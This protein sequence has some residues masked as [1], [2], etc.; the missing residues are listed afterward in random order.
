MEVPTASANISALV[1]SSGP[2]SFIQYAAADDVSVVAYNL[3][4]PPEDGEPIAEG[5]VTDG[6]FT[7]E[8]DPDEVEEG[9]QLLVV[10]DTAGTDI[11]LFVE[12][13]AEGEAVD[14]GDANLDTT[15]VWEAF[16]DQF[17]D[18]GF[19]LADFNPGAFDFEDH[20]SELGLDIDVGCF[21]EMQEA[22]WEMAD[23]TAGGLSD[24]MALLENLVAAAMIHGEEVDVED[25][26]SGDIDPEEYTHLCDLAEEHGFGDAATYEAAYEGMHEAF[27]NMSDAYEGFIAAPDD[28]GVPALNTEDEEVSACAY[29]EEHGAAFFVETF[30]ECD[31]AGEFDNFFGSADA[32]DSYFGYVNTYYDPSQGANL[33]DF[34]PEAFIGLWGSYYEDNAGAWDGF[35]DSMSYIYDM[36]AYAPAPVEGEDF[37]YDSWGQACGGQLW[38]AFDAGDYEY[39]PEDLQDWSGYW[40]VQVDNGTEFTGEVD[41]YGYYTGYIEEHGDVDY[42]ACLSDPAACTSYYVPPT[43]EGFEY[44]PPPPDDY[45][46][47][48][49]GDFSC[50]I[51]TENVETCGVDCGSYADY[52]PPS[53][54]GAG[55][56]PS[57]A[58]GICMDTCTSVYPSGELYEGYTCDN[59]CA[60][61]GWCATTPEPI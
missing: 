56:D 54:G 24:D 55:E 41:F 20:M 52:V 19:D 50:D 38:D 42:D 10:G 49:C 23:P 45:D 26:M 40:T 29:V 6:E 33:D 44:A 17:E 25:L 34:N 1:A 5:T 35:D 9:D 36:Y 51:L 21:R 4:N 39:N 16:L 18:A 13:P 53:E 27:D 30:F 59:Y 28:A 22:Q 47:G 7:M 37:D 3:T 12:M 61:L 14:L 11:V 15:L 8:C 31:D 57:D 46:T 43:G 32:F 2:K 58:C 48:Y 60:S